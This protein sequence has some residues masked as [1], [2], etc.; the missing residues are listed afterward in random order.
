MYF[1]NKSTKISFRIFPY[2][3]NQKITK[4]LLPSSLD[5]DV[6]APHSIILKKLASLKQF[7]KSKTFHLGDISG[8]SQ[9]EEV[10]DV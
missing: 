2:F 4:V 6:Y 10:K 3:C 7:S 8:L 9:N 1:F 5:L